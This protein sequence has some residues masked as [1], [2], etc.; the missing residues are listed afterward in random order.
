MRSKKIVLPSGTYRIVK[1]IGEGGFSYVFLVRDVRTNQQFALKQM[2]C[3]DPRSVEIA[4]KEIYL[5]KR[6]QDCSNVVEMISHSSSRLGDNEVWNILM[7]YSE[8]GSVVDVMNTRLSAGMKFFTEQMVIEIFAS[9]VLAI[10]AMHTLDPPAAHRDIKAENILVH[11]EKVFL[12]DFGSACFDRHHDISK[13]TLLRASIDAE[14]CANTTMVYRAPELADLYRGWPITEKT[15][16]WSLGVLLY[17]LCF[18][19][20]PFDDNPS[21]LA[22]VGGRYTFPESHPFSDTIIELIKTCLVV[23][24]TQRPD[25]HQLM[26]LVYTIAQA[27]LPVSS[28]VLRQCA[29][30]CAVHPVNQTWNDWIKQDEPPQVEVSVD[31]VLFGQFLRDS[32]HTSAPSST[33]SLPRPDPF[34]E[35]LSDLNAMAQANEPEPEP[36]EAQTEPSADPT[37]LHSRTS[38]LTS[39][40]SY[41]KLES[42]G[43][44]PSPADATPIQTS[45]PAPFSAM[46]L[47]RLITQKLPSF[48]LRDPVTVQTLTKSAIQVEVTKAT[49]VRGEPVKTKHIRAMAIYTWEHKSFAEIFNAL[50][51][52]PALNP[53][54]ATKILTVLLRVVQTGHPSALTHCISNLDTFRSLLSSWV[55]LRSEM[56]HDSA[57]IARQLT[58]FSTKLRAH[59]QLSFLSPTLAIKPGKDA[60]YNLGLPETAALV[61]ELFN[62]LSGHLTLA[63]RA[64][65]QGACRTEPSIVAGSMFPSVLELWPALHLLYRV[66]ISSDDNVQAVISCSVRHAYKTLVESMADLPSRPDL[67][68]VRE[69]VPVLHLP[70]DLDWA[71]IGRLS[72]AN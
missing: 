71:T 43:A 9:V 31:E 52:R 25:I 48:T 8:D 29:A 23:D 56:P 39:L 62:A 19:K 1:Q 28:S 66:Y 40:F 67:A 21:P 3:S 69:L 54:V 55:S 51:R 49:G 38:S 42:A 45:K 22:I 32:C 57:L 60:L 58:Y 7:A 61:A 63:M 47:P 10:A 50:M 6:L 26:S 34:E 5:L 2:I 4:E 35:I 18:F 20:T 65:Q 16:I 37:P 13:D 59:A 41:T 70:E 17:K 30:H 14:V 46:K 36:S 24:P 27:L 12:T 68:H 15:D 11:G 44:T 72:H 53:N 64:S 33:S